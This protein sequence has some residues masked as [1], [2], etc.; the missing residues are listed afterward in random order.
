MRT[1]HISKNQMSDPAD[2][3]SYQLSLPFPLRT[4]TSFQHFPLQQPLLQLSPA[5]SQRSCQHTCPY[6]VIRRPG[7]L[8]LFHSKLAGLPQNQAKQP[9][10]NS[11]KYPRPHEL[12]GS[13]TQRQLEGNSTNALLLI[14]IISSKAGKITISSAIK[15]L[16]CLT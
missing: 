5:R 14:P 1:Q 16:V 8:L 9:N 7:K 13:T 6:P 3:P 2:T 10:K 12:H 11:C 15:Q 4:V